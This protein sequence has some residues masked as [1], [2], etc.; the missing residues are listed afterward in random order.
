MRAPS[1]PTERN[2]FT[3][4]RHFIGRQQALCL[5]ECLIGEEGDYF[6]ELL[7]KYGERI[8]NM[9][10]TYD[11]DG[12]GDDAIVTL[13]YF[14]NGCD[15]WISEKDAGATDDENPGE[16]IQAF[17]FANLGYGAEMGYISIAELIAAGVEL[18][19]YFEPC[20]VRELKEQGKIDS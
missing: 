16:Q 14:K 18:D 2:R 12:K 5:G 10:K 13:H 7:T 9:P 11:Q 17:G 20:T 3:P 8:A 1:F 19:L 6:D 4:L 15:W